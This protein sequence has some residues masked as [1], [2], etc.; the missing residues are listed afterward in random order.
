[1]LR[2]CRKHK[3]CHNDLT[4]EKAM[5][6]LQAY[7]MSEINKFPDDAPDGEVCFMKR[8]AKSYDLI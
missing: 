2:S 3:D 1:M 4:V 8:L 6:C 5:G 7:L